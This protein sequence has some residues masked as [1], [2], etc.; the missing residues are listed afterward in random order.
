M[1]TTTTTTTT[2]TMLMMTMMVADKVSI[3]VF[4]NLKTKV[5]NNNNRLSN[6]LHFLM[7]TRRLFHRVAE[8]HNTASQIRSHC[9]K[10]SAY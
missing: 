4:Y 7:L 6:V 10:Y 1:T 2:T 8:K 3:G 9:Y 5:L